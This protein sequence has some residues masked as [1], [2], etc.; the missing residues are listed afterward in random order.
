MEAFVTDGEG[1]GSVQQVPLPTPGSGEILVKIHYSALNPTDWKG[2]KGSATRP[3]APP[4]RIVGCDFAGTVVDP[5]GSTWLKGQRVAGFVQGTSTNGTGSNPIRGAFSQFI[6]VESTLVYAIPDSISFQ[7]AA[8]IPLAFATAV[9]AMYQRLALPEPY[10]SKTGEFFLVYGGASSVGNYAIQL[11][12]LSGMRVIATASQKNHEL[13]RELGAD[14]LVDYHDEDW[15]EQVKSAS[16]NKLKYALDCIAIGGTTQKI[17]QALSHGEGDHLVTIVPLSQDI[18][19]SINRLNPHTT[20]ESTLVYTVFER[21]LSY[22]GFDNCGKPTPADKQ[23]WE[24]FLRWLPRMLQEGDLKPNRIKEIGGLNDILT[25]FKLSEE[26]KLSA[27]KI[28][29]RIA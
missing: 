5:N 27:E 19:D 17:A 2:V 24:K 22:G 11:G 26:G 3:S 14:I 13:L 4:G 12:K 23:V 18:K 8:V 28:V 25:G 1:S 6:P 9:Q 15:V 21:A 29:Y 20:V 16:Q 7:Q 10:Q